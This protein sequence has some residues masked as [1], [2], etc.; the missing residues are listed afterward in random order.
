MTLA[1]SQ[2]NWTTNRAYFAKG[3]RLGARTA[4]NFTIT[5]GFNPKYVKVTNLTDRVTSEWFEDTGN[6]AQLLTVAAGTRTYAAT[7]ISV[8]DNVITVTVATAGLETD[9]DA[10][11]WE[12][13]G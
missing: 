5:L 4:A 1:A 12:A 8:A 7:G 6:T 13:W 10:V 2:D 9:D 3:S 11:Y